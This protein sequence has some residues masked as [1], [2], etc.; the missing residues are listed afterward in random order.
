[1][2]NIIAPHDITGCGTISP[3][4]CILTVCCCCWNWPPVRQVFPNYEVMQLQ[5]RTLTTLYLGSVA[6][7]YVYLLELPHP[8]L[9][10]SDVTPPHPSSFFPTSTQDHLPTWAS[11]VSVW[12]YQ[13]TC[14]PPLPHPSLTE[15]DSSSTPSPPLCLPDSRFRLSHADSEIYFRVIFSCCSAAA[16]YHHGLR[17]LTPPLY[18]V[19]FA[20][21]SNICC[22]PK[23]FWTLPPGS[24]FPPP[25]CAKSCPPAFYPSS[26]SPAAGIRTY[27]PSSFAALL[28]STPRFTTPKVAPHGPLCGR[29]LLTLSGLI[30]LA[31]ATSQTAPKLISLSKFYVE[32]PSSP[33][34]LN[35]I[36]AKNTWKSPTPQSTTLNPP[37]V[38][39]SSNLCT[40]LLFPHPFSATS[41]EYYNRIVPSGD[42]WWSA[43]LACAFHKSC[44]GAALRFT[45]GPPLSVTK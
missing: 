9:L 29:T 10:P 2:H 35:L 44:S 19:F 13:K 11:P 18:P 26:T 6:Y 21:T 28:P 4:A 5:P 38:D 15:T 41:S 7:C 14:H 37:T 27:T 16:R 24:P 20:Q 42:V 36:S 23:K 12:A 45:T 22:I 32:P 40:L 1:M 3:Y 17:N 39:W 33:L 30:P 8:L 25:H 31:L 43:P 34:P